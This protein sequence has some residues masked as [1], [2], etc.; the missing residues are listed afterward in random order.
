M[1]LTGQKIPEQGVICPCSVRHGEGEDHGLFPA[2]G[3]CKRLHAALRTLPTLC[4][5]WGLR[6]P[7]ELGG[8]C[9]IP[10]GNPA[11]EE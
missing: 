8:S 3:Q 4:R 5:L 10:E 2:S 11:T 6:G 7:G 9:P 1:G